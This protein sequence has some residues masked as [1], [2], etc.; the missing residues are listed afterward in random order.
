MMVVKVLQCNYEMAFWRGNPIHLLD[1]VKL[2]FKSSLE[3]DVEKGSH[4][5]KNPRWNII[6]VK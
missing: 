6:G 4:S 5:T 3:C 2:I 1:S